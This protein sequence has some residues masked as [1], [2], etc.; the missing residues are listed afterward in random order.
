MEH[1]RPHGL[2]HERAARG[3]AGGLGLGPGLGVEEDEGL[4]LLIQGGSGSHGVKT[5]MSI[6]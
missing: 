3:I 5:T 4:V 6:D 1:H 2:R